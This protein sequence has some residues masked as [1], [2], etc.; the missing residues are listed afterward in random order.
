MATG[1]VYSIT[2]DP[3]GAPPTAGQ[4]QQ[5]ETGDIFD[6]SDQSFSG[7][8]LQ[9]NDHCT[10]VLGPNP[11]NPAGMLATNLQPLVPLPP[12]NI[13]GPYTGNITANVGD[14]YTISSAAAVVTGNVTINGGK[15]IVE[16][17]GQI[18]G[19]VDV[20]GDGIIVARGG[21]QVK[22]GVTMS[23]GG[24]LKVVNKGKINGNITMSQAGR[25][26]VGNANGPGF[27]NGT[28]DI[29]KIRSFDVTA[30]SIITG[31]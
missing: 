29:Q 15:V 27:I 8:N 1:I 10:F 31:Q 26:I 9:P 11:H 12:Q 24:S 14:V 18:N 2:P 5:D 20:S 6:F 19:A 30:G 21:G 23:T 13:T 28:I 3:S 16:Q 25:M 4:V 22:G 7:T 17:N